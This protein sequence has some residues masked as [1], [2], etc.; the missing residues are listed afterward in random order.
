M[1]QQLFRLFVLSLVMVTTLPATTLGVTVNFSGHYRT[2]GALFNKLNLGASNLNPSK[3]YLL[4]RVLL[5]PK[6]VID[7]HFSLNSQINVLQSPRFTPSNEGS[8][9]GQGNGGYV[10]GDPSPESKLN[11]IWL[12]WVS[13][14]GVVRIGRMP[15]AWGY[16]LIYDAGTGVWDD[17]QSTLD[18]LEYRLHF[19]H[20]VGAVAYS[21]GGK[22]STLG[23]ENDQE[24]YTLY[25][26]YDN[27]EED[28]EWGGMY[29]RQVR[30]PSQDNDLARTRNPLAINS[31][32]QAGATATPALA[33]ASPY[34]RSNNLFD[35]YFR[36]TIGYF[37]FGGE[38]A[39][40]SG[41]AID[42]NG[43]GIEDS[44]NA[45]GLMLNVSYNYHT[46]KAFLD[47]LYASGDSNIQADHLNGFTLLHRNRRPGLIL[48]RELLGNFHNS[49]VGQGSLLY[50]GDQTGTT[51]NS[52][53]GAFYFRPGLRIDWSPA[54]ASGLEFIIAR[55][56][57]TVAGENAN[58]GFEIDL[59]TDHEFYKNFDLGLTVGYLFPGDGIPGST[60]DGAFG[61]RT[62]AAVKF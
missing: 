3:A 31:K 24:F 61:V 37:T 29:E 10:F 49:S 32:A 62:T 42:F 36:R 30:S 58:L 23:N 5:N 12:E 26:R 54:W 46:V 16:G 33:V 2:E 47:F 8:S 17:F 57:A 19:G 53:S 25:L 27:P 51:A 56:A 20:L 38:G 15:I 45:F 21:K 9:L 48:G 43:N 50:Y 52:F 1:I 22:L 28:M 14:F 60:G 39:W 6:L 40:L 11:R 34:P 13:D 59:G 7:D 35:I 4:G 18:R 55:K 41:T 44:L